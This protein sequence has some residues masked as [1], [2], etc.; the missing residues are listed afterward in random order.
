MPIFLI[1]IQYLYFIVS[2]SSPA[3]LYRKPAPAR[4][5]IIYTAQI[6][7]KRY[8]PYIS[9]LSYS[10]YFSSLYIRNRPIHVRTFCY[11]LK[12]FLHNLSCTQTIV[13][14]TH[15][16]TKNDD[17]SVIAECHSLPRAEKPEDEAQYKQTLCMQMRHHFLA[18]RTKTLLRQHK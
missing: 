16:N 13:L 11:Y 3:L 18:E 15:C 12:P 9:L 2:P 8:A 14:K 4:T 5:Y 17:V 6:Y 7:D 10:S 1:Y